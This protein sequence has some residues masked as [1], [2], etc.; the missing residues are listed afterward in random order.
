[1]LYVVEREWM[2]IYKLDLRT[3]RRLS[4][5]LDARHPVGGSHHQKIVV[6]DDSVAF[7]S[8]FDLTRSRWDSCEHA[9]ADPRRRN[10]FNLAYGPFHDVGAVVEGD[11][12]RA[13]GELARERWTARHG[14]APARLDATAVPG[15]WPDGTAPDFADVDVAIARTEPRFEC[16]RRHR[17]DPPAA[18]GCDRVGAPVP[19]RREPVLHVAHHRRRARR[20]PR[21]ARRARRSPSCRRGRRAAGSR[22]RR[23]ACCARAS[24]RELRAA[25]REQRYRLLCPRLA[26]ART[27]TRAASTSTARCSIVDD[28]FATHR[29]GQPRPTA[30]WASTPSA[31]SRSRR[32][33]T[34]A[35]PRRSRDFASGCSPSTSAPPRSDVHAAIATHG[36]LLR[37]IDALRNPHG[38][39]RS[40][41]SSPPLDPTLDALVAG[42]HRAR[43]GAAASTPTRSCATSC[44]APDVR[45]GARRRVAVLRRGRARRRGTGGGLALRA[46]AAR[47][48]RSQQLAAFGDALR[49]HP[50]APLAIVAAFVARRL[51]LRAGDAADRRHARW[52]SVRSQAASTR[53]PARSRAPRRPTALG[54][55]L[56][57]D[58]VRRLAGSALNAHLAAVREARADR[59]HAGPRWCRSRRSPSSTP[60]PAPRTSAGATSSSAPRSA[61]CRA[62]S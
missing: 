62:S 25:D 41:R 32:A 60:W 16:L 44:A 61:C 18:P 17:R 27:A 11:C 12:A 7:V 36:S 2:P 56:G 28:A 53:S 48:S 5:R 42:P 23:W 9:C 34:R 37:A 35:S 38:R 43:S 30:R 31:T 1:M 40:S 10:P 29:L 54:R 58:A 59:R 49:G 39:R 55:L 47:C 50:L 26:V 46:R 14:A 51:P 8:G 57:R 4:F 19:L 22:C 45:E 6:V 21:R 52:C 33:A 15:H 20:A 13:L 24:H 3:H